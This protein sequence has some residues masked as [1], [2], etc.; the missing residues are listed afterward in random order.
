MEEEYVDNK[1]RKQIIDWLSNR[2]YVL[3]RNVLNNNEGSISQDKIIQDGKQ[4]FEK[5]KTNLELTPSYTK[6]QIR[7]LTPKYLKDF[8]AFLNTK[9][10][11]GYTEPGNFIVYKNKDRNT[12]LHEISHA[13]NYP[14][15]NTKPQEK[16]IR[17]YQNRNFIRSG[18]ENE[19]S[20]EQFEYL[21]HPSEVYSRLMQFRI[22]NNIDPNKTW[23][24]QDIQQ[25]RQDKNTKDDN[26]INLYSDEF[27]QKL[28]NDV[29]YNNLNSNNQDTYYAKK[30]GYL[31]PVQRFKKFRDP[32]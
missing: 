30:G 27:I 15:S 9:K 28:F 7:F 10:V 12:K 4:E 29:A 8:N 14:E 25:L 16:I 31:S 20:S 24:I 1:E 22:N 21:N 19:F 17:K 6:N 18:Y 23:S 13:L 32:K 5:Q 3:G 11:F 26:L 2:L